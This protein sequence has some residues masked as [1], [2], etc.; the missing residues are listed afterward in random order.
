M[1]SLSD[2][3]DI[4][5]HV[6]ETLC[7][8]DSSTTVV[9]KS[10]RDADQWYKWIEEEEQAVNRFDRFKSERFPKVAQSKPMGKLLT[11][12]QANQNPD[13]KDPTKSSPS[14]QGRKLIQE[15]QQLPDIAV[16][17]SVSPATGVNAI[18]V[19]VSALKRLGS[20]PDFAAQE[21][22]FKQPA[23]GPVQGPDSRR[24]WRPKSRGG[25]FSTGRPQP[26]QPSYNDIIRFLIDVTQE[27]RY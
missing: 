9:A 1:T 17:N 16:T 10:E 27:R 19:R 7:Q 12:R 18:P 15:K 26:V 21:P 23:L 13:Q 25:R 5:D 14:R 22:R 11:R 4:P 6:M 8:S 2:T 3:P 24:G 20:Q